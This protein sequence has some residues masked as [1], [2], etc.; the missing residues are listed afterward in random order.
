MNHWKSGF[1]CPRSGQLRSQRR[2]TP[3]RECQPRG[4]L[5]RKTLV[6]VKH[7]VE[8]QTTGI[9]WSWR[10]MELRLRCSGTGLRY[11]RDFLILLSHG[12]YS[13]T[14]VMKQH[15][16]RNTPGQQPDSLGQTGMGKCFLESSIGLINHL[17][18]LLSMSSGQLGS[19]MLIPCGQLLCLLGKFTFQ[20][21]SG[22]IGIMYKFERWVVAQ[23]HLCLGSGHITV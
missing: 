6:E 7:L 21:S 9:A 8:N 10:A 12:G 17:Y 20:L 11:G 16:C 18:P 1:T 19:L 15:H 3:P 14:Y 23:L 13:P 5:V 22:L 2:A 4:Y